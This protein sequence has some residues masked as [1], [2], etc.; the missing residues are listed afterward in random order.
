MEDGISG[1]LQHCHEACYK[2]DGRRGR[3]AC[4]V[5]K[6]FHRRD[7]VSGQVDLHMTEILKV[8]LNIFDSFNFFFLL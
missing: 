6:W 7:V 3:Q 4:I 1:G 5:R 2:K 8:N